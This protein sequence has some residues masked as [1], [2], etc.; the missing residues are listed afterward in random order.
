MPE[1]RR[2]SGC[3]RPVDEASDVL[4]AAKK[5]LAK[6]IMHAEAALRAAKA[7]LAR[8]RTPAD[9]AERQK[10]LEDAQ[11]NWM[12][13][14]RPDRRWPSAKEVQ[15]AGV[16]ARPPGGPGTT[17]DR[18]RRPGRLPGG[19]SLGLLSPGPWDEGLKLLAKG[20]DKALKSLATEE[21]AK[22]P[23]TA[24]E[25][26]AR[27]DAWWELAEKAD[28]KSK[29]AMRQ[30]A[31]RWYERCCRVYRRAWGNRNWKN[32]LPNW[33][34]AHCP[35]AAGRLPVPRLRRRSSPFLRQA[36]PHRTRNAG[37]GSWGCR[38]K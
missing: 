34:T 20:S 15:Q 6:P 33:P 17:Q 9:K 29:T 7:A 21:L 8:A 22:K 36:G 38:S 27:G 23:S 37:P 26:A 19:R 5:L 18:A 10:T 12:G 1:V 4:D 3:R 28:G 30:R 14:N 16:I 32:G 11:G 31:G 24:E 13:S 25:R 2:A 35:R